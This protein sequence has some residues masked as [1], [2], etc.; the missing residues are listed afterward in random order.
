MTRDIIRAYQD[1][2]KNLL[3]ECKQNPKI[4]D[5]PVRVSIRFSTTFLFRRNHEAS[6]ASSDVT[7]CLGVCVPLTLSFSFF[8]FSLKILSMETKIPTLQCL[9]RQE[10]FLRKSIYSKSKE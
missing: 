5:I 10:L 9:P 6:S 4:G 8:F 7:L 2:S 1:F 3:A